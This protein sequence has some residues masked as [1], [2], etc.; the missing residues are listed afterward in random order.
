MKKLIL[1]GLTVGLAG[2]AST[3]ADTLV[4]GSATINYDQTVWD[5]LASGFG[6]TPVLTLGAFF[7]QADANA[8]TQAQL[9][10]DPNPGGGAA[11]YT[12][13][14]YAM[15][16]PSVVNLPT[17]YTQPTTFS[18]TPGDL[19][20]GAGSIGLGGVARFDVYGGTLGSLLF[21]DFTLQYDSSRIPLGGTGWYLMGNIP[22]AAAVFDLLD[23]NIVESPGSFNIS[24]DLGV[25]YE[26]A[27]YLFDTPGDALADVGNFS[28]TATT[29]PEPSAI[30][31]V[32]VATLVPWLRRS[33]TI[34]H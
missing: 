13:E 6:P 28:F 5:S 17:R 18:F 33:K 15:N 27:N 34:A 3:K 16:G 10:S 21:G 22:P 31:L 9:L 23:V 25:S 14:V 30:A 20:G 7:D 2:F 29:V 11:P 19:A 1:V 32:G 24:G 26:V 12:G 4:S 8:R